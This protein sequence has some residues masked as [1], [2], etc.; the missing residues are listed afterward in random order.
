MGLP[1]S[2]APSKLPMSGG[3]ANITIVVTIYF[4]I[5]L[6]FPKPEAIVSLFRL[7]RIQTQAEGAGS[8]SGRQV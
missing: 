2:L 3:F 4:E 7:L 1:R 5:G 8:G 6:L